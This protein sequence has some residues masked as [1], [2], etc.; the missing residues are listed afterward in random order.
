MT[1]KLTKTAKTIARLEN[2]VLP[3]NKYIIEGDQIKVYRKPD[4]NLLVVSPDWDVRFK[5]LKELT[6]ILGAENLK[7]IAKKLVETIGT[8][9]MVKRIIGA[10]LYRNIF[11]Y[12]KNVR[13][14]ISVKTRWEVLQRDNFKCVYCGK[15]GDVTELHIDH[16]IPVKKG[17]TYSLDN[18][19]TA[20]CECNLGKGTR[21]VKESN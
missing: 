15:K 13:K 14:Q 1:T 19:V 11:P 2:E 9:Q 5:S 18:L 4:G 20:C 6:E 17:G 21:D 16:K 8:E 12:K 7:P 3:D 10:S